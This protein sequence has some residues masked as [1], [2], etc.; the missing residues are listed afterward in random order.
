MDMQFQRVGF[1]SN[2][3][4][5]VQS[6]LFRCAQWP[7]LTILLGELV[8]FLRYHGFIEEAQGKGQRQGT[9]A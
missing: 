5:P 1:S 4:L 8:E 3:Q 9:Q 2:P 6:L 7:L